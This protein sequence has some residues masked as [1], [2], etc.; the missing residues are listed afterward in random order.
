MV[1]MSSPL[2]WLIF[3]LAALDVLCFCSLAKARKAARD[4]LAMVLDAKQ[5]AKDMA[6]L[7]MQNPYPK[8]Q[9]TDSGKILFINPAAET[10]FQGI[11]NLGIDHPAIGDFHA[12]KAIALQHGLAGQEIMFNGRTYQQT[13]CTTTTRRQTTF[14]IY[15]Y[16]ISERKKYEEQMRLANKKEAE[17]RH[18]AERMNAARGEF[19]ANM[20]HELRTPMNG[21]LGLS[22]LLSK[23]T[24]PPVEQEMAALIHQSATHLLTI[25]NDILDFSK[26]EAGELRLELLPMNIKD[27]IK[28][29]HALQSN[30]AQQKNLAFTYM[31]AEHVPPYVMGDPARFLQIL[32]N[33]V[34]NAIKFTAQGSVRVE[35]EGSVSGGVF[36]TV[37]HVSDTGIGIPHD[38]QQLVFA[39]FCQA[40]SST[41]RTFGGTGLGLS[42][43]RELVSMFGGNITL[44]S[45]EGIGTR[46]TVHLPF[47]ICGETC[48][49]P[50]VIPDASQHINKQA[51]ILLVDDS[52]INL[53]VL[54]RYLQ[55]LGFDMI[56]EAGS[57]GEAVSLCMNHAYDL[58]LMDIQMP[59]MDGFEATRL[60]RDQQ[61]S[62]PPIIIAVT[63]DA[64]AG[65]E[66]RCLQGGMDDYISKPIQLE[67][68]ELLLQQWLPH[69][70][71]SLVTISPSSLN[72]T[73]LFDHAYFTAL[74][75]GDSSLQSMLLTIFIAQ[76]KEDVSEMEHYLQADNIDEW[77]KKAHKLCGSAA[78]IGA[79]QIA[80]TCKKA[81][82]LTD[83][84]KGLMPHI[85]QQII[86]EQQQTLQTLTAFI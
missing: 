47:D 57:G 63:A 4:A 14:I 80:N 42:I 10:H 76:L 5:E 73:V 1:A 54:K 68:L 71:P 86:Q 81:E 29:M 22:D 3:F 31:V 51:R 28:Q 46:F 19:L 82:N 72:N 18:H 40:E 23:S 38:K 48:D 35:V 21:I 50:S 17:A 55:K 67:R 26:I 13:I 27:L 78:N 36:N 12:L 64:M 8:I 30:L 20:S 85:H 69:D 34:H 49:L 83:E 7:P 15:Y 16:D 75:E 45:E 44:Q 74:T 11:V 37:I 39:K 43:I 6:Q 66:M 61:H 79:Y 53:L 58:I 2:M 59:K 70:N 52:S 77:R 56:D 41:A 60:I 84:E 65:A 32:N 24:L 25:L 33:L 62:P 9:C